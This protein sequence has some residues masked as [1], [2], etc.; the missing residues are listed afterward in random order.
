MKNRNLKNSFIEIFKSTALFAF[1]QVFRSVIGMVKNK[2]IAV[3]LGAEG[4]GLIGIYDSIILFMQTLAGLG[5]KQSAVKDIAEVN[6]KFETFSRVISLVNK[7]ILITA[8]LGGLINLL[9]YSI[10][11]KLT[12]GEGQHFQVFAL[13]SIVIMLNIIN[14]G[15]LTVL[16]GMRR[17]RL[18]AY[19]NMIGVVV[20]FV[21]SVP[22]YFYYGEKGILPVF[23]I[24]SGIGLLVSSWFVRKI[25][26]ERVNLSLKELIA[27]STPMIRMGGV[28]MLVAFLDTAVTLIIAS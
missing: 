26:Y 18:L 27:E 24:S 12:L 17:L 22:L 3:L 14:E 2:V 21:V 20:A 6:D 1:V 9:G 19:A 5:L 25:P 7:V 28:L 4:I 8:V 10:I 15:K 13:L 23:V 11:G 16:K